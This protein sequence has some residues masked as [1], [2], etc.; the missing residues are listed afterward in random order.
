MSGIS[1]GIG[2]FNKDHHARCGT[3]GKLRYYMSSLMSQYSQHP[4][5]PGLTFWYTK[6]RNGG[7]TFVNGASIGKPM[8]NVQYTHHTFIRLRFSMTPMPVPRP[9]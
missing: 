5:E 3:N 8:V 6:S 4:W 2:Q 1:H 7:W 9:E